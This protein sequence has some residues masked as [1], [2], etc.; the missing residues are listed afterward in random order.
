MT[1]PDAPEQGVLYCRQ[2]KDELLYFD[3]TNF[4]QVRVRFS[5]QVDISVWCPSITVNILMRGDQFLPT[6]LVRY[7]RRTATCSQEA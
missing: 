4:K 3:L 6:H 1:E 7:E 2:E 5:P